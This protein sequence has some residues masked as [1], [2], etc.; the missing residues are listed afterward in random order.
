M[1]LRTCILFAVALLA[2]ACASAPQTTALVGTGVAGAVAALQHALATNQIEPEL[3][4][5]ILAALQI[6][7]Q[8]MANHG[9]TAAAATEAIGAVTKQ[10]A[11]LTTTVQSVNADA[12]TTQT[13]VLAS[14]G[15]LTAYATR[16]PV[17]GVVL[18]ALNAMA[19]SRA[20]PKT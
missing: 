8:A 19:K 13:A 2:C 20:A 12:S 11:E 17:V 1:N 7:Q 16:K 15:L 5:N 4:G 18:A 14:G 10:V 3:G 6:V 9:A